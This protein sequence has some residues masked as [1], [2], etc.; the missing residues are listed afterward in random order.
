M[1]HS[2]EE[3]KIGFHHKMVYLTRF[4]KF[5]E[6]CADPFIHHKKHIMSKSL[7]VQCISYITCYT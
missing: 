4:K 3:D 7:I 2:V 6:I 1:S 5:A